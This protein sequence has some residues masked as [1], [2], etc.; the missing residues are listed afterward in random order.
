M[1]YRYEI[2]IPITVNNLSIY[3]SWLLRLKGL[4]S[5]YPD[6]IIN[7]IYFDCPENSS[8]FDNIHG[9]A[10]RAKFRLRW[11]GTSPESKSSVEIKIKNGRIGKKIVFSTNKKNTDIQIRDVF[12]INNTWFKGPKGESIIPLI[13]KKY[14]FPVLDVKYKRSYFLYNDCIRLTYDTNFKSRVHQVEE[15]HNPWKSDDLDV[16]EIKFETKHLSFAKD[17]ISKTPFVPKRHSK[18][19]RGLAICNKAIYL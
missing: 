6:R 18:Y 9:I 10:K 5:A 19:L 4:A 11:Y 1:S 12:N 13:S 3:K 15:M 14:L 8:A 2:K 17:F 16:L 7:S